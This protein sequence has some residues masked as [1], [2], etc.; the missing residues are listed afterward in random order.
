MAVLR[1]NAIGGLLIQ[2]KG[3]DYNEALFDALVELRKEISEEKGLPSYTVFHNRA[4]QEMAFYLPKTED[5]FLEI[6]GVGQKK[7]ETYGK[8]FMEAIASFEE[9][10]S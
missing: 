2:S 1:H 6:N 10:R 9:E 7:L 8:V 3:Q 5:A 4:L